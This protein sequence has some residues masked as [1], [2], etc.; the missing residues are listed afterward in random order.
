MNVIW[1]TAFYLTPTLSGF[2]SL[3]LQFYYMTRERSADGSTLN[4]FGLIFLRVNLNAVGGDLWVFFGLSY[5]LVNG[6]LGVKQP[7]S[8]KML[9]KSISHLKLVFNVLS[10]IIKMS[11]RHRKKVDF[12]KFISQERHIRI[13]IWGAIFIHFNSFFKFGW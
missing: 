8:F 11:Y 1:I 7:T 10:L 9:P 6:R 3:Y 12:R 13:L 5:F 4:L 2:E